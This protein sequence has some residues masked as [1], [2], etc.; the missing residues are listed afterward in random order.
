M[1]LKETT[2]GIVL[3]INV[4]P[5]SDEL[6]IYIEKEKILVL[7]PESPIKNKVNKRLVKEF[8]RLF[9]CEVNLISGF[10]SREKIFLIKG[11][12]YHDVKDVLYSI[13]NSHR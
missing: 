13:M 4:K 7:C 3:L 12:N 5:N 1:Q 11:L 8:N 9:K 6:K 2:Q 10:T